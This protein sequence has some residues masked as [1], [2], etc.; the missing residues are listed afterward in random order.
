MYSQ[1]IKSEYFSTS[2]ESKLDLNF[3]KKTKKNKNKFFNTIR[4]F[5]PRL[6]KFILLMSNLVSRR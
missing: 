3:L 6:S 5:Y 2:R 4:N 1:S